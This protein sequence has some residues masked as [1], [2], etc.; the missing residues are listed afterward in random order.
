MNPRDTS[1]CKQNFPP[2]H[3]ITQPGPHLTR[4][5]PFSAACY[6]Y[7]TDN[8]HFFYLPVSG[9]FVFEARV[10]GQYAALYDQAGLMVRIDAQ[11]WAKCGTE[12]FTMYATPAWSLR[13]SS[14]TGRR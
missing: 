11:N 3:K 13:V 10:D 6:G 8:G 12:L 9:N 1:G 5:A 7:I 4:V 14:P 2:T